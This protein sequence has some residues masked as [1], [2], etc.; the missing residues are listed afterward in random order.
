[1]IKQALTQGILEQVG[2]NQEA[3]KKALVDKLAKL[4]SGLFPDG[5]NV[6]GRVQDLV[7]EAVH[8]SNSMAEEKRLFC[9]VMVLVGSTFNEEAM[10]PID[11]DHL[12]GRVTMCMLPS[13]GVRFRADGKDNAYCLVK[14]N[15]ELMVMNL[16]E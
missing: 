4:L 1:M 3:M 5:R 15:V 6:Q 11:D 14:A 13:F 7:G 10:D 8:L 9:C 2:S 16:M 12:D